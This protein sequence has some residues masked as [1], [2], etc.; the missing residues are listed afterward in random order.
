MVGQGNVL[1]AVDVRFSHAHIARIGLQ[2][3]LVCKGLNRMR[4]ENVVCA[5]RGF[6]V[7]IVDERLAP[8]RKRQHH[9]AISALR[10]DEV[11]QTDIVRRHHV[12]QTFAVVRNK[13]IPVD[14]PADS[15]LN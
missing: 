6:Q 5:F 4:I 7:G 15:V 8:N 1:R 9:G 3:N 13:R 11:E 10:G 14:E 2:R 12:V